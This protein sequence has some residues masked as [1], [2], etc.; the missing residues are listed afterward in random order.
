[1]RPPLNKSS[2]NTYFIDTGHSTPTSATELV[3]LQMQ[4][5]LITKSMD[6]LPD[7]FEID[8]QTTIL[9]LACG[10]GG[11]ALEVVGQFPQAYVL[12][13]DINEEMIAYACAQAQAQKREQAHFRPMNILENFPLKDA[14][15]DLVNAR[16]TAGLMP[17]S[18]WPSFLDECMRVTK[19]GGMICLTDAII[20]S[21]SS[22][23]TGHQVS[24]LIT[25]ALWRA[26]MTFSEENMA[27]L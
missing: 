23:P 10:P 11:W 15:F 19:P 13:V 7:G 3:R 26:H 18:K 12:G 6:L 20:S 4:D 2:D 25:Q 9:D 1:M 14:S 24:R 17:T 27:I 8:E 22:C 21:T 5:H 16:F